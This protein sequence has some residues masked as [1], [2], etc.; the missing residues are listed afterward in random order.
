[1]KLVRLEFEWESVSDERKSNWVDLC[2]YKQCDSKPVRNILYYIEFLSNNLFR[3]AS[4][5]SD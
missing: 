4:S 3:Q 2:T 1:M 5:T